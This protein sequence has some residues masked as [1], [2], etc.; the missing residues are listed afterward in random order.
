MSR[1]RRKSR[2]PK[3]LRFL[4]STYDGVLL[5][6][7]EIKDRRRIEAVIAKG[8]AARRNRRRKTLRVKRRVKF[9]IL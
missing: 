1:H 7:A 9:S 6:H 4:A 5:T 8:L 3:D 2:T